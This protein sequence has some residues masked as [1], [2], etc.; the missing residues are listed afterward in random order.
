MKKSLS[1]SFRMISTHFSA[2]KANLEWCPKNLALSNQLQHLS[3]NVKLLFWSFRPIFM[4]VS[5]SKANF[6][7][8]TK[9]FG[10]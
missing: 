3:Y 4:H 10:P 7:I 9:D 5:A 6:S 2:S 8:V 1:W